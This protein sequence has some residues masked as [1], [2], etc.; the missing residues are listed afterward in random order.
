[1]FIELRNKRGDKYRVQ[2]DK[3][4]EHLSGLCWNFVRWPEKNVVYFRTRQDG[5]YVYLHRLV[6]GCNTSQEIG[7][8]INGDTYDNR[9]SNLRVVNYRQN[10]ANRGT[11]ASKQYK[12]VFITKSGKYYAC[13]QVGEILYS[14]RYFSNPLDAAKAY[15]AIASSFSPYS[16]H[17]TIIEE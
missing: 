11:S 1:M 5:K 13:L 9:S 7:D 12:G 4:W 8:H 6:A 17:N 15:N 10:G 2:V 14:A 16:R 3:Q